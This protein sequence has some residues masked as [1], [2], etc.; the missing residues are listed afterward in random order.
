MLFRSEETL[1]KFGTRFIKEE[2]VQGLIRDAKA[3]YERI[4]KPD[5]P[6]IVDGDRRV[7]W[8]SVLRIVNFAKRENVVNIEFAAGKKQ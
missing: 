4:Q 2:E 7:P 8:E 3:D 5:V 1:I 6:V